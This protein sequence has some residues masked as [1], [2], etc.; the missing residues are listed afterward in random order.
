MQ[1]FSS[2]SQT[3]KEHALLIGC[4]VVRSTS[5]LVLGLPIAV[6]SYVLCFLPSPHGEAYATANLNQTARIGLL[7]AGIIA[8]AG[9]ICVLF[10]SFA[11]CVVFKRH[12]RLTIY[13][14]PM[15]EILWGLFTRKGLFI[16]LCFCAV[17]G[18][19]GAAA[20]EYEEDGYGGTR[21]LD[22]VQAGLAGVV[23]S[24]LLQIAADII[25]RV[26][27]NAIQAVIVTN[28]RRVRT[29]PRRRAT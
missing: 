7:G 18:M 5:A 24:L 4:R 17:Q 21:H 28:H 2:V 19:V 12:I 16:S 13:A 27:K 25:R 14:P 20:L 6:G 10:W 22:V 29:R 3:P 11:N 1:I 15:K 26:V 8:S 23:G 9:F